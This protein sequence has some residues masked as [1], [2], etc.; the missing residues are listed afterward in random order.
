MF[1]TVAL[2]RS[3]DGAAHLAKEAAALKFVMAAFSH[4][5]VIGHTA[6]AATLLQ[7]AG[8]VADASV[9]ALATG[10]SAEAYIDT[11]KQGCIW[12]REPTVRSVF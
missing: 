8:V 7:V 5:K 11:A 2:V 6:E 10:G 9:I 1:D 3:T 12:D 4:L